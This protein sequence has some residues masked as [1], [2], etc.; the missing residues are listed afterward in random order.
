MMTQR[1]RFSEILCLCV[2][3]LF[4]GCLPAFKANAATY[5]VSSSTG[6]DNNIGT[7][8]A[9][10][11]KTIPKVNAL[12]LQA[13]DNVLF[14]CGDT[15]RGS[16]LTI[17]KSG[18]SGKPI[19]FSSYPANCPDKPII[20]GSQPIYGWRIYSG[21]IYVANLT[22]GANAGNFNYGV[23]QLFKWSA[24]LPLGRWPNI[25]AGDGGYST[26][27]RM[28]SSSQISDNELPGVNWKGAVA[29]IRG[30]RWYILNRQ[31]TA[32][33]G[34][35]LSLG[36]TN[37]CWSGNC[38]GWGYF[39]NNHLATLDTDG[40]WYYDKA[41]NQVYLYS[42]SGLPTDRQVEG[43]VVFKNDDRS[44]GGINLGVDSSGQGISYVTIANLNVQRWFRSG[45]ATPT[46]FANYE[47]HNL[48]IQNNNI[49]DVDRMGINLESW[50]YRAKDGRPDGWRGGYGLTVSGNTITRANSMGINLRSRN[51][52]FTAN[53]IQDIGLIQN[54]GAA[55]MGCA[56]NAG[57]GSCT[58]DGAGIRVKVD[59]LADSA[60]TNLIKDNQLTRIAHNGIDIFGHSNTIQ[61][62]VIRQACIAKGD[63]GAIR[64]FGR[65]NLASTPVYN[66]T[67][68]NN[69]IVDTLGNTH[70]CRSDFDPLFGFGIYIDNFSRNVTV[71]GNSVTNST[72]N[73][74][75]FQNSTGSM[76]GNMLYNNGK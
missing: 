35:T 32:N 39:L 41:T 51:S 71:R 16:M 69:T 72:A 68:N 60:N 13:G 18:T 40:E 52:N 63:C 59:K 28:P 61:N 4:L 50:V 45:I 64:T 38:T 9:S 44:W 20:S 73:G 6:N 58:E 19:R 26:I 17:A 55:G 31:V 75:L 34:K 66:V 15:W 47:P 22:T 7:S 70:G 48:T 33:W 62:N 11:L 27:D 37:D 2:T 5:Y 57:G 14:K 42:N 24:R 56:L 43:S 54:L 12:N 67:I 3:S 1:L 76:T 29:H 74:I 36:A 49:S 8:Q 65:N 21:K 25:N 30:M 23:N 10:P 46:N 53:I